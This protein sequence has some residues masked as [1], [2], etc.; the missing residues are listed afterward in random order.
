[1]AM[2]RV[3]DWTEEAVT[4]LVASRGFVVGSP[5][6]FVASGHWSDCFGFEDVGS[7]PDGV[8]SLVIRIGNHRADFEKDRFAG[9]FATPSLPV[10]QVLDVG[11][12]GAN[13][14]AVSERVFGE[15]LEQTQD[16][17]ALVAPTAAMLEG[18]RAADVSGL[19]G[20]GRWQVDGRPHKG[21][22]REFLMSVADDPPGGRMP[23]WK[24]KLRSEPG[25]WVAFEA[26]CRQLESTIVDDVPRSLVHND[27]YHRNVHTAEGAIS[28][29]FDWGIS[30]VGDFLYDVAMLCFWSPWFPN[31]DEQLLLDELRSTWWVDPIE[32]FADRFRACLLHMGLEHIGYNTALGHHDQ[33]K[34]IIERMEEVGA[35]DW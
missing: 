29:V 18:L 13:F 3:S 32:H 35:T 23:R 8:R 14:F 21:S 31:I 28:G 17:P 15:P 2:V 22:W 1:M 16:W 33:V 11:E 24:E 19:N 20:W 10:P 27:L 9:G 30:F 12:C 4:D 6:E 34:R 25:A 26:G 7:P 5:A